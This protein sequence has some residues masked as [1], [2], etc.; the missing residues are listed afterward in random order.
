M[1]E[2]PEVTEAPTPEIENQ[3]TVRSDAWL[4]KTGEHMKKLPGSAILTFLSEGFAH[5]GSSILSQLPNFKTKFA[6]AWVEF[7]KNPENAAKVAKL[8]PEVVNQIAPLTEGVV[9][10]TGIGGV[11]LGTFFGWQGVKHAPNVLEKMI[12]MGSKAA[13]VASYFFAPAYI[14]LATGI[15]AASTFIGM[16]HRK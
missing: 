4:Q 13:L 8:S 11:L 1:P 6:D 5:W 2:A 10:A 7:M 15:S 16:R 12:Y 3:P 14:P 9:T